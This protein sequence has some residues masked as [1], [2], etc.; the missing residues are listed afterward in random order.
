MQI[1]RDKYNLT[2]SHTIEITEK[3]IDVKADI[4]LYSNANEI[5]IGASIS[6]KIVDTLNMP[7]KNAIVKLIDS[8]LEP[9]TYVRTDTNGKYVI[10]FIPPS[11]MYK[12]LA[13]A[14]GKILNH[15]NSFSLQNGENKIINFT[16]SNDSNALFGAINGILTNNEYAIIKGAVIYLYRINN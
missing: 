14:T 6:G 7:I 12:I 11:N 15:S 3:D 16:L 5:N 1:R 13:T 2:K 4:N 9:L 10:N 8:N